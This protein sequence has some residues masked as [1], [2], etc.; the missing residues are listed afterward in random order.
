MTNPQTHGKVVTQTMVSRFWVSSGGRGS[1]CW[2]WSSW[3]ESHCDLCVLSVAYSLTISPQ[4][5]GKWSES[6]G[7]LVLPS[8]KAEV[9]SLKLE[10][11]FLMV[12]LD[13]CPITHL[14]ACRHGKIAHLFKEQGTLKPPAESWDPAVVTVDPLMWQYDLCNPHVT[15]IGSPRS[16]KQ[17]KIHP[18]LLC[19][20]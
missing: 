13:F 2:S 18:G 20:L 17:P 3:V 5:L 8:N 10:T 15:T 19:L 14:D 7:L 11:Y 4:L 9:R 12:Y 16:N 1:I 6:L